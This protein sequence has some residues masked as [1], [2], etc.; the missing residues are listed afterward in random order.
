MPDQALSGLLV[1][2]LSEDISG[3]Y[4]AKLLADYGA[5]VI[6]IEVPGWGDSSRRRGPFPGDQPHQER[7]GLFLF[8]NTNKKGITLNIKSGSGVEIF[9]RLVE[10][11]DIVV[12]N[13][14]P[15]VMAGL[16]LDYEALVEV[17]PSLIMTSISYFGQRGP[18]RDYQGSDIVA[19]AMGGWMQL[20]G[21]PALEPLKL[22]GSQ[23]EFQAGLNAAVATLC[24]VYLR[25]QSGEGQQIDVSLQEA[26]ASILESAVAMYS[27][28]R[29]VRRR[30]G[31]RHHLQCPSRAMPCKD[32]W[33]HVQAGANWDHFATFLETPEL[34]QPRLA[35]I[36]RYR[37][38]DEVEG[39]IQPWLESR[40]A[41]EIFSSAQEWRIPFAMVLGIDELME[42]RQYKARGFFQ[43]MGHP[44]AGRFTY[45]GAPFR[46]SETPWQGRRAPLLGEHNEEIYCEGLGFSKGDLARLRE[47]GVI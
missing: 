8:L 47:N 5:E 25:D 21:D 16:G 32:G 17:K 26:V 3:P 36:L 29:F 31:S 6:K 43:E 4:C 45:P 34:M 28:S 1:L 46:M 27:Y 19:Q 42:D 7:S 35:S 11:A 13:F 41:G 37:Y 15:G 24:A 2:D 22:P 33:I 12:E 14:R 39:L 20:T 38:A 9:K 10:G 44:V 30:M 23:A 18:Y 40:E